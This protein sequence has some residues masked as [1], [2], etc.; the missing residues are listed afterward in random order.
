MLAKAESDSDLERL[1]H[2]LYITLE[3]M[4][5]SS[6]MLQPFCPT[7]ASK[8]LDFLDVESNSR[9]LEEAR[10]SYLL[11]NKENYTLDLKKIKKLHL[12][13]VD[14]ELESESIV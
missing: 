3:T 1:E 6:I 14:E 10:N 5:L 7:Q 9:S 2:V 11:S 12:K 8:V 13:K 4:R